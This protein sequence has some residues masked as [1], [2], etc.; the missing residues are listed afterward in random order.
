MQALYAGLSIA[1]FVAILVVLALLRRRIYR[2][3]ALAMLGL[4]IAALGGVFYGDSRW[5]GGSLMGIGILVAAIDAR[6]V[7]THRQR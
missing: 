1:V 7:R 5:I 2:V 4:T 3:S 6:H